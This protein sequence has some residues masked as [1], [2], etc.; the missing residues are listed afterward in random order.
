[1]E[2]EDVID[3]I[4]K[5]LALADPARGGTA[6]EVET[7]MALAN[8]LMATHNISMAEATKTDGKIIVGELC[9]KA[10]KNLWQWEQS[11]GVVF[12]ELCDVKSFIRKYSGQC[13]MVFVGITEDVAVASAMYNAFRKQIHS[14]GR[15]YHNHADHRSYGEGYVNSLYARAKELKENRHPA[16]ECQALIFV[17]KKETAIK[18]YFGGLNLKHS[19]AKHNAHVTGAYYDGVR[20]GNTVDLGRNKRLNP[21]SVGG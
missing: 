1:M 20:D 16:S 12:N 5:L 13:I 2:K 19:K 11:L 14:N 18:E 7:A 10:P 4:I 15:K 9:V 17:G 3:R 6:A 21:I 8:K